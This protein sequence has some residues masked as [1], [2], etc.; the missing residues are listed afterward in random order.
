M[1]TKVTNRDTSTKRKHTQISQTT[2]REYTDPAI[3]DNQHQRFVSDGLPTS[4]SAWI[5]RAQAVS[6][7]FAED[8]AAR[9][10]ENKSPRAEV[11][12]LKSAGLLKVL[13]PKE[14]GGGGE[15]WDT[16][17]KVIREVAKGDGSLGMLL[18]YHLLWSTIGNVVG[19]EEQKQRLQKL[20]IENNYFVG[21]ECLTNLKEK[22]EWLM[23]HR[24]CKST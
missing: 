19:T 18:G 9:D 23:V 5:V 22:K 17:Y 8:A 24:C 1:A 10:I 12:L 13:G 14:Y 16:A 20:I 21:G 4:T 2:E 3:Y 15:T 11:T 6:E 7:I